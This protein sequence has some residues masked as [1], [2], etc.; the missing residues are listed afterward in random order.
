LTNHHASSSS[1]S[2][3]ASVSS[4]IPI[5]TLEQADSLT[6]RIGLLDISS[7]A[8]TT[9]KRGVDGNASHADNDSQIASDLHGKISAVAADQFN[10]SVSSPSSDYAVPGIGIHDFIS[11]D[12]V[13]ST[14][15][16]VNIN[17][18][19]DHDDSENNAEKDASVDP[20]TVKLKL[21]ARLANDGYWNA[22]ADLC[23]E[24]LRTNLRNE[25]LHIKYKCEFDCRLPAADMEMQKR[26]FEAKVREGMMQNYDNTLSDNVSLKWIP[27]LKPHQV[28]KVQCYKVLCYIVLMLHLVK[29]VRVTPQNVRA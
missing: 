22:V 26:V 4:A 7:D 3:S 20:Q 12:N 24:I 18:K 8:V 2:A 25:D 29:F 10:N 15:L 1:S 23:D 19:D 5:S 6:K 13:L 9:P 11:G 28:L 16:P 27:V 14:S 17:L 21:M